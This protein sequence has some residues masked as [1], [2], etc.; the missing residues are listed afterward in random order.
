MRYPFTGWYYPKSIMVGNGRPDLM[1]GITIFEMW[2]G[3]Q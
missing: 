1:V 3:L 2:M